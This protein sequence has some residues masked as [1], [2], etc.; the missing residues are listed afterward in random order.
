MD[1]WDRRKPQHNDGR[2]V[3]EELR[4]VA[5]D[6]NPRLGEAGTPAKSRLPKPNDEDV[7][8]T[9]YCPTSTMQKNSSLNLGETASR[10]G[11]P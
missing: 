5:H 6:R 7:T 10:T 8:G 11:R 1:D 2:D 4:E 3:S 9:I